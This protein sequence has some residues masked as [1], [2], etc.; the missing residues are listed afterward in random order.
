MDIFNIT[1]ERKHNA[2]LKIYLENDNKIFD[3]KERYYS[4][5]LVTNRYSITF[6]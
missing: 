4:C 6:Q 3:K 5:F 1:S 2:L